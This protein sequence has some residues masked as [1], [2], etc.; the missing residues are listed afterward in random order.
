MRT[1]SRVGPILAIAALALL[2]AS[3]NGIIFGTELGNSLGFS[4]SRIIDHE[5]ATVAGITVC[6]AL[7]ARKTLNIAYW[8]TAYG[9]HLTSGISG[10]DAFYG[11]SGLFLIGGADGLAVDEMWNDLTFL[12][13]LDDITAGYLD[14][15]ADTNVVMWAWG[16]QI[17]AVEDSF[18]Y[19]YLRTMSVLETRFPGVVFVYMTGCADGGGEKGGA[20]RRN[21]IIREYC[22]ANHKWLY[23]F[24][25][26]Q[27]YGPDGIYYGSKSVTAHCNYD[28]DGDGFV[29]ETGDDPALPVSP[30]RNWALDWQGSHSDWWNCEA[31]HSQPVDA[32]RKAAA[33]WQ[34]WCAIADSM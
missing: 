16:N 14:Q 1:M 13:Y 10:M 9:S 19:E 6:R 20:H 17:S 3:C 7:G 30:D 12:D 34:L 26:I 32:N 31:V 24:Y 15:N 33:A 28:A 23:D 8:H 18:V 4:A 5:A 11:G 25:D 29:G 21:R 27:C 2:L 22:E